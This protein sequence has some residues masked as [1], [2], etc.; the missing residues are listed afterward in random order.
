MLCVILIHHFLVRWP[1]EGVLVIVVQSHHLAKQLLACCLR[2]FSKLASAREDSLD[3]GGSSFVWSDFCNVD[4]EVNWQHLLVIC[5]KGTQ[6][7]LSSTLIILVAR[8]TG[9]RFGYG[10]ALSYESHGRGNTY[11][12][13]AHRSC[14][15]PALQRRATGTVSSGSSVRCVHYAIHRRRFPK[16]KI[17]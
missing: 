12:G 15:D 11:E 17:G 2:L 4:S 1:Q 16:L 3:I 9:S 10:F 7:E 8:I 6:V 13:R 14:Q 5:P